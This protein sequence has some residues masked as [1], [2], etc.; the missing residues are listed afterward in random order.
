MNSE[1]K[2]IQ[3]IKRHYSIL[4]PL[5]IFCIL[6]VVKLLIVLPLAN[7]PIAFL[8]EL[9]YKKYSYQ[10]LFDHKQTDVHYPMMYPLAISLANLSD[11]WYMVMKVL[12]IVYSS[13]LVLIVYAIARLYLD[14]K[15]STCVMLVSASLP[16]HFIFPSMIMSENLFFPLFMLGIYLSLWDEKQKKKYLVDVLLGITIT[17]ICL[18]RYI[19]LMGIP[20]F[21]LVWL[22]KQLNNHIKWREIFTR[23]II[24]VSTIVISYLP[25][26]LSNYENSTFKEM[27]GFGITKKT[28]VEQLT[29][30]RLVLTTGFYGAYFIILATPVL[31]YL[32]YSIAMFEWKNLFGRYNQLWVMV[33]GLSATFFVAV[34]RHSWRAVYNYPKYHRIMGRYV[35]Y[36]P[37]LYFLLAFVTKQKMEHK[38]K[39]MSV[40]SVAL[41]VL[42]TIMAYA[43]FVF[44]YFLDVKRTIYPLGNQFLSWKAAFEGYKFVYI[45]DK[46]LLGVLIILV[47]ITMVQLSKRPIVQKN[48][49]AILAVV[50]MLFN[51][52]GMKD[53]YANNYDFRDKIAV[54]SMRAMNEAMTKSEDLVADCEMIYDIEEKVELAWEK[55]YLKFFSNYQYARPVKLDEVDVSKPFYVVCD[56]STY[57][58]Y[59]NHVVREICRFE[60]HGVEN[61]LLFVNGQD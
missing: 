13:L 58:R 43:G 50:I 1:N 18:T 37:V 52:W 27:I 44:G 29:T 51:V 40:R 60:R 53:F 24:I 5:G 55:K 45:G 47:F 10:W 46:C 11:N 14:Q 15:T 22:M 25:W 23:G 49:M 12:N 2:A 4:V 54:S 42:W 38:Q 30:K 32:I 56:A 36:F 34:T 16:Y 28:N 57:S 9:G 8:D 20:V 48:A 26:F 17:A 61:R 41:F 3:W 7:G 21:A 33:Y 39:E 19:G 31:T 59:E 35:I 6:C